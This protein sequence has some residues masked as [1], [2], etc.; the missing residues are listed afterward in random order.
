MKTQKNEG[1]GNKSADKQYRDGVRKHLK[2]HDVTG[3]AKAAAQA[4]DDPR[5]AKELKRAES[6]GRRPRK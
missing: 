6:A 3:E 5:Q 2:T 1:E 4:L